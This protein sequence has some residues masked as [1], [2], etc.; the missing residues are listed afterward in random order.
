MTDCFQSG[1]F[2]AYTD[3]CFT[4]CA[5]S[6]DMYSVCNVHVTVLH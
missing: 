2:Y 3:V 6:T 4:I 1:L 5:Y